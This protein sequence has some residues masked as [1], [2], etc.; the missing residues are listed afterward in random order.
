MRWPV[1]PR[2]HGGSTPAGISADRA[3]TDRGVLHRSPLRLCAAH[4]RCGTADFDQSRLWVGRDPD[5]SNVFDPVIEF[6][7]DGGRV[8][9]DSGIVRRL[10]AAE[11]G[12]RRREAFSVPE[13]H[14]A[15]RDA[16]GR[17]FNLPDDP[18]RWSVGRD[19]PAN[20]EP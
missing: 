16:H 10:A 1:R 9:G 5:G 20:H 2:H 4:W 18:V 6:D 11:F 15:R 3:A 13:L 8:R 14:H 17:E 12:Y 7:L 19:R